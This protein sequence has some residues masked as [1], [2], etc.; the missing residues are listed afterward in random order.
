LY[1]F[2]HEFDDRLCQRIEIGLRFGANIAVTGVVY[3][4]QRRVD[5]E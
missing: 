5:R 4:E 3:G 2:H 1:A